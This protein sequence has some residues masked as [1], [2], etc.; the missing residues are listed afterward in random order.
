[1]LY[2]NLKLAFRNVRRHK[3]FSFINILGLSIGLASCI[4]IGL[5]TYNELSFDKF[6]NNH[7]EVY[8][9]NKNTNEKGKQA[10]QDGITPGQLAPAVVKDIP[11]IAAAARFRPWFTEMLVSYD[12]VHLKLDDVAYAD[13]SFLQ[14][15]DFP[16]TKG[17]KSTAL[18]GPFA[19]VI[20][21]TTAK[22]YF[23]NTDP[24]GKT[25]V[26]L[27]NIPVKITGVAKDV[28][29]NSSLQF[30]MLIL[31]ATVE[32]P[33]NADYFFWMN[34]WTTNVDYTFVRLKPNADPTKVGGK[35]S[36]LLHAHFPE[37]EFQYRTYLQ[38]LDDIHLQ[39]ADILYAEQFHTNSGKIIYTLLIIAGFILL[40]P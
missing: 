39:S 35:I 12:T 25:V 20:T 38:P 32:A 18:S 19:A 14:M 28:P 21:E 23:G 4:I 24:I 2:H 30:T 8:R 6:N 3:T 33:A 9:I 16:L 15:F 26:T 11:E 40:G 7:S 13:Q 27:N 36:S 29:A 37:T 10:Q 34:T 22:K 31:F 1:M 17:N 5:Y